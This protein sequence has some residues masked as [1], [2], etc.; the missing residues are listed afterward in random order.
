MNG[1]TDG[2]IEVFYI[3]EFLVKSTVGCIEGLV[4]D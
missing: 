2:S 4:M 3:E 1:W